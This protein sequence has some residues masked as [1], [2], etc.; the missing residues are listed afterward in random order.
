[1]ELFSNIS[2]QT[3][4]TLYTVITSTNITHAGQVTITLIA[5]NFTLKYNSVYSKLQ[6]D[7]SFLK[8][9][10]SMVVAVPLYKICSQT[11]RKR[12][13]YAKLRKLLVYA[14]W[15]LIDL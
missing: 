12:K 14:N 2:F 13:R 11:A 7:T 5:I 3:Y 9:L 15:T 10:P 1:M 8:T 4:R 6:L